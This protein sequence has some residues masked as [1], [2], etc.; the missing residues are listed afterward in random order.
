MSESD[1]L[2]NVSDET[3]ISRK[4]IPQEEVRK[5]VSIMADFLDAPVEARERAFRSK[6][7]VVSRDEL[8]RR[9][10]EHLESVGRKVVVNSLPDNVEA[11]AVLLLLG[12]KIEDVRT[13]EARANNE[14]DEHLK[15][16]SFGICIPLS[17][18]ESEIL[19]TDDTVISVEEVLRHEVVHAM[20]DRGPGSGTGFQEPDGEGHRVNEAFVQLSVETQ[21]KPAVSIMDLAIKMSERTTAYNYSDLVYPLATLL[22]ATSLGSAPMSMRDVAKHYFNRTNE[23][24]TNMTLFSFDLLKRT[25]PHLQANCQSVMK[26]NLKM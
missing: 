10:I 17:S 3:T 9:T 16:N 14:I 25:P 5:A 23:P 24:A 18:D 2:P 4:E 20:A 11:R 26:K 7:Y 12:K 1:L 6:A 22:G 13:K 21:K 19:I 15:Y 8:K